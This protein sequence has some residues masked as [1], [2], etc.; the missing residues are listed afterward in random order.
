[1]RLPDVAI[2]PQ[3]FP[4]KLDHFNPGSDITFQQRFLLDLSSFD[5][6]RPKLIIFLSSD[7]I[8]LEEGLKSGP[9]FDLAK[10]MHCL[11]AVLEHRFW[12]GS[13]PTESRDSYYNTVQQAV[14]DLAVFAGYLKAKFTLPGAKSPVL[15][16][17]EGY[18][19]TLAALCIEK[20]G[21]LIDFVWSASSP[22]DFEKDL[23]DY[24]LELSRGTDL[25]MQ[26]SELFDLKTRYSGIKSLK[27][28]MFSNNPYDPWSHLGLRVTE[29]VSDNRYFFPVDFLTQRSGNIR[30][31]RQTYSEA[32]KILE[33]VL[34]DEEEDCHQKC[35]KTGNG[36]C[37]LASQ[38]NSST[39]W[40]CLCKRDGNFDKRYGEYCEIGVSDTS[41]KGFSAMLVGIPA[42]IMIVVGIAAWWLFK[43]EREEPEIRTIA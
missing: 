35:N 33:R 19:G 8:V 12:G 20:Y 42:L 7:P 9:V 30:D 21:H 13:V 4:Q 41:F 6:Q 14:E 28:I 3:V 15:V 17:G 2:Q 24:F 22:L 39:R 27:N 31:F 26:T 29:N 32:M 23:S 10:R 43:K 40:I 38:G 1:M 36:E 34:D 5:Y 18:G 16:I 11:I 37:V 25:A